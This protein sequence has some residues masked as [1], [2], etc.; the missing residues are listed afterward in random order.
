MGTFYPSGRLE[1]S[2]IQE[3]LLRKKISQELIQGTIE[4]LWFRDWHNSIISF[5]PYFEL[6]ENFLVENKPKKFVRP[7]F[8]KY[9]FDKLLPDRE[10]YL[11]LQKI[12]LYF[13]SIHSDRIPFDDYKKLVKKLGNSP[14]FLLNFAGT[15]DLTYFE[16]DQKTKIRML[17]WKHHTLSEYLA[18][19][20]IL[21]TKDPIEES[22]NQMLYKEGSFVG[23]K[24]SWYGT[25]RFLLESRLTNKFVDWLIDLTEKHPDNIDDDFSQIILSVNSDN[26]NIKTKEKLFELIYGY[27][28][29]QVTWLPAY[30][31]LFISKFIQKNQLSLLKAD[32][33]KQDTEV[34]TY[35]YQGNVVSIIDSLLEQKSK[36]LKKS[37][38]DFWRKKFIEFAKDKN[39]NGVLQRHSLDALTHYKDASII[40]KVS[41]ALKHK[42]PLVREAFVQFC[43]QT[44][45]N[46]K[47][48]IDFM[49]EAIKKGIVIYGRYGLY[50]I[51][52]K[53]AI[54]YL[55]DRFAKDKT[56]L[57]IFIDRE[58]IFDDKKGHGD[59]VLVNNIKKILVSDKS[60]TVKDALENFLLNAFKGKDR[61]H[62]ERS[63]FMQE[64]AKM[65]RDVDDNFIFNL[66]NQT[67]RIHDK[68]ER[69][70]S[71]YTIETILPF[72][73]T[74]S[75]LS[76]LSIILNSYPVDRAEYSLRD[77]IRTARFSL[78]EFGNDLYEF[79]LKS[80]LIDP[81]QEAKND[82][83]PSILSS[84]SNVYEEFQKQLVYKDKRFRTSLFEFFVD[85][86]D[87]I[88]KHI[89]LKE[90]ALLKKLINLVL[91]FDTSKLKVTL[92][93]RT[94]HGQFNWSTIA[95]YYGD[96]LRAGQIIDP[97]IVSKYRQNI[98][99]LIPFS[100]TDN[101]MTIIELIKKVSD[102]EL[103]FVYK[104]FS[105]R[106]K[107]LRYFMPSAF[108][109]VVSSFQE[110]GSNLTKAGEIMLSLASDPEISTHDRIE[111]LEKYKLFINK[112]T[113]NEKAVLKEIEQK[114]TS[115][116]DI[117]KNLAHVANAILIEKFGDKE[118]IDWRFNELKNRK[119]KFDE[120]TKL[121]AHI[122][123]AEEEELE[124]LSLGVPLIN[125][126]DPS[127][128]D[129]FLDLLEY[130]LALIR[131]EG[132]EYW[133]YTSYLW[134]IVNS[135]F[136]KLASQGSITPY[137]ELKE[138][139]EKNI[140]GD[141]STWYNNYLKNLRNY[142]I[143][144]LGR[145]Y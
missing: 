76:K 8:Y 13:E 135:Y 37:D 4:Q 99:N 141:K 138:W 82:Q 40:T 48:S 52:S 33:K 88:L 6:L 49:I 116:I 136:E 1:N 142:Y 10:K 79:A 140:K 117:E 124:S 78:G 11:F 60:N 92:A 26:L 31:R 102:A 89:T 143:N 54:L 104:V 71:F 113:S 134:R 38:M 61:Y 128:K 98:I 105:N 45:P 50:E 139:A 122:V 111:A 25:L 80:N 73:V 64:L 65:I 87:E 131:N 34:K 91:K 74:K 145:H 59:F 36:L 93:S 118:S 85:N 114:N 47:I 23:F 19:D 63:S 101:Q 81:V 127:L 129:R 15:I 125:L 51:T 12:A 96:A 5:K 72:L 18:S 43:Y 53:D 20:Y 7:E 24:N 56:F 83:V 2:E 9:V 17:V 94:D 119:F 32:I 100:F 110:D 109:Q 14:Y 28:K 70:F 121:E 103:K 95:S 29:K 67:K 75:N 120:K 132:D 108:I 112:K 21:N 123:G 90:K 55:L 22:E 41:S 46:N 97:K 144:N 16:I 133:S 106:N 86:K 126:A 44:D 66:L 137:L 115:S 69:S 30:S 3:R 62:L 57:D 35:V 42:E 77:L 84:K 68:Q 107:D 58:S 130:S 39:E 27:Y